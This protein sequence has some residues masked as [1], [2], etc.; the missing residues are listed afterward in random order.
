MTAHNDQLPVDMTAQRV[1]HSTDCIGFVG[2]KIE[3]T[4]RPE[5]FRSPLSID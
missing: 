1:E 4:S 3:I 5:I 2:V